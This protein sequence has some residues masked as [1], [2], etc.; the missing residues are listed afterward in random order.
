MIASSKPRFELGV[1]NLENV[2]TG[3]DFAAVDAV[4]E[5]EGFL[6]AKVAALECGAEDAVD[7]EAEDAED[8]EDAKDALDVIV[9][10]WTG[11][12]RENVFIMTGRV[13]E[14]KGLLL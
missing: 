3:I 10:F 11:L 12:D 8:A 4:E 6:L 7:E 14:E 1:G 5:V 9:S 13:G 2:F